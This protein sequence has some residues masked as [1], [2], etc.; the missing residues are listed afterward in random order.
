MAKAKQEVLVE[1]MSGD[2]LNIFIDDPEIHLKDIQ[3]IQ[4]V[5]QVS[6]SVFSKFICAVTDPRYNKSEVAQEIRKLLTAEVPQVFRED[7]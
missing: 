3:S 1:S 4:G 5:S 7:K 6:L 2:G